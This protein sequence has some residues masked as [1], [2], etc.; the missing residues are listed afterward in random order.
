METFEVSLVEK[1]LKGMKLVSTDTM[2]ELH[3][4]DEKNYQNVNSVEVHFVQQDLTVDVIK[5]HNESSKLVKVVH[6]SRE[7]LLMIHAAVGNT[8]H[9]TT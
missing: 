3:L 8:N 4:F 7:P 2:V 1:D 5:G 9:H 6:D